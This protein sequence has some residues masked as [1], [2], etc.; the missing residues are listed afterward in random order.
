MSWRSKKKHQIKEIDP[1][2]HELKNLAELLLPQGAR[3]NPVA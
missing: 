3:V 2:I 1:F